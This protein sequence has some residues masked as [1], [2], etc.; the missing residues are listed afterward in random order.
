VKG[1]QPT[2]AAA[3]TLLARLN[4]AE[5][6]RL[7]NEIISNPAAP[8]HGQLDMLLKTC[9]H[10]MKSAV[11]VF[12]SCRDRH[13]DGGR[14]WAAQVLRQLKQR[15]SWRELLEQ[16]P[17]IPE[18]AQAVKVLSPDWQGEP[19]WIDDKLSPRPRQPEFELIRKAIRDLER[20]ARMKGE[21][22][23]AVYQLVLTAL[24]PWAREAFPGIE[25]HLK[26]Y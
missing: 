1:P 8:L 19:L 10:A 24:P 9:L 17:G 25:S 15:L 11:H 22:A 20:H 2:A 16:A 26:L 4:D 13:G 12:V 23:A 3:L 21:K 18:A 6:R 7:L 14:M 5:Q